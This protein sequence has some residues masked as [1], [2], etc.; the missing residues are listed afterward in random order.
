MK[1]IKKH[2]LN[3][4][5]L[6]FPTIVLGA[7]TGVFTSVVVNIYKFIASHIIHFTESTYADFGEKLWLIPVIVVALVVISVVF[8]II[9]RKEPNLKGGGIPSSIAA[10]K[11]IMKIK[12]VANLVGVFVLSLVSFLFGV[13]LG[14]EGPSVQMGTAAGAGISCLWQKKHKAWERYSMTGG[15]CAG[16]S[17]ATGAPISGVVFAIEEAHRRISPMI[18]IVA[19]SS[20]MFAGLT[21]EILAPVLGVSKSLF[22]EF[23][24]PVLS[25][26]EVYIPLIVGLVCGIIAV[27]F[28]KLYCWLDALYNKRMAK[29]P[30]QFKIF[31]VF[32]ITV[33]AGAISVNFISTGHE[34]VLHLFEHSMP[35][36]MLIAILVVRALLTLSA[37][38]NGITGGIFLPLLALGAASAAIIANVGINY[39][40]IDDKYYTIILVFGLVACISAMMKMPLT[41]VVF[42]VEAL[43]CYENIVY[44]VLVAMV[45]YSLTEIFAVKSIND[46]VVEKRE[47]QHYELG[48]IKTLDMTV[49]VKEGAFAVGR[50]ISDVLWPLGLIVL[51]VQHEAAHGGSV[52]RCGDVLKLRCTTCDEAALKEEL[53]AIVGIQN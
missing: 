4:I 19:G 52:L 45:S 11:G 43:G 28:L 5:N 53:D 37:N 46:I 10:L 51:S 42:A 36:L 7:I 3:F 2:N 44:V 12:W 13:P 25:I 34:L 20:V 1:N 22:P 41:S 33:V 21:T 39:F 29:V 24:L 40:S 17:V 9:Y 16:F 18:L 15:A 14:N 31:A 49:V 30:H 27:L 47:E 6:F 48:P 23:A 38:T 26:K 32:A 8:A 35:L 50:E